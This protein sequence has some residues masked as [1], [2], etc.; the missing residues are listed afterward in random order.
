MT[1]GKIAA[2]CGCVPTSQSKCIPFENP[3]LPLYLGIE[4]TRDASLLQ[5]VVKRASK[6]EAIVCRLL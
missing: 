2:Q 4:Q 5:I 3:E 6:S 1:P